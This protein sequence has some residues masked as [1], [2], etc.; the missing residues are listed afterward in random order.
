MGTYVVKN[1]R[2]TES[3][4]PSMAQEKPVKGKS[5]RE[6]ESFDAAYVYD[7]ERRSK[8]LSGY[9]IERLKLSLGKVSSGW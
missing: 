6:T 5:R 7:L 9:D 1:R 3:F 2:D 4:G 8:Y